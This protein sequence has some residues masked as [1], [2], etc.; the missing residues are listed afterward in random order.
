MEATLR[1]S[2]NFNVINFN[3]LNFNPHPMGIGKQAVVQFENGYGASIV[4]STFTYGGE[5]GLY[6]LAV[7]G[8]DGQITYETPITDD[9]IGHLTEDGVSEVLIQI[10]SL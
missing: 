9:V 10:Q 4:Q 6:E 3:E 8:K 2:N 7:F 5:D 1:P